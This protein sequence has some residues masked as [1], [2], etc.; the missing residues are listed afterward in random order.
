MT[1]LAVLTH[2]CGRMWYRHRLTEVKFDETGK[3]LLFSQFDQLKYLAV[4]IFSWFFRTLNPLMPVVKEF[5]K[6]N[7]NSIFFILIAEYRH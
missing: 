4:T 5:L 7:K 1:V 2:M 3:S 6:V